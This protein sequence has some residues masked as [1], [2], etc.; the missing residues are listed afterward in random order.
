MNFD[1]SGEQEQFRDSV[2][3]FA[4]QADRRALRASPA[5][6]ARDRW[7]ALADLGLIALAVPATAGGMG[8]TPIDLAIA[9][10]A[11]GNEVAPDPWLENGVLPARLL[12]AAGRRELVEALGCGDVFVALAFAERARRFAIQPRMVTAKAAGDDFE[13]HGEKTFVL[14]GE[15][16]DHYIVSADLN[17]EPAFFLIPANRDGVIR[18]AYRLVDGSIASEIR[19]NR[20]S[21][22]ADERLDIAAD[23]VANTIAL[24]RLLAAAEMLGLA[25]KLFDETLTYLK[26]RE[27]FGVAIGSFQAIQH[28]M[29]DCY[30]ALEQGRSMVTRVALATAGSDSKSGADWRRAAAGAKAYLAAQ[31]DH[32]AREA[33]Q[34]HGGMGITDDL[35]IGHAMK[36]V[37]LLARLFGDE[38]AVL[39]EYAQAA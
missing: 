35:S 21:V 3:R 15:L 13:V 9:A 2:R 38:D 16:A 26:Q 1:L 20:V 14:G 17:G 30:A 34:M 19:F 32:I 4:G 10:E 31:A 27:Q 25:Q 23:A 18:Q 5:G 28:R 8:G 24:V 6:Y 33:V 22:A 36:R 11:L 29:V 37:L 12:A 39:A 7:T